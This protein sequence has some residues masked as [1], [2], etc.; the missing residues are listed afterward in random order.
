MSIDNGTGTLNPDKTWN[1][2]VGMLIRGEIN[3]AVSEFTVT[4][5]RTHV[6]DFSMPILTTG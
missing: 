6:I 3:I 5:P 2:L 4:E 1:G